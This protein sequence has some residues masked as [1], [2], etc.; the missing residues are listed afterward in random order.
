M[1]CYLYLIVDIGRRKIVVWEVH[2]RESADLAAVL[3][4]QA[5]LAEG[6]IARPL[7]L[8]ADN[9]SPPLVHARACTAGQWMKVMLEKPGIVASCSRPRVSN[10]SLFSE[11]LFRTCKY[12][13][14][15]PNMGFATKACAQTW[16]KSFANWYNGD[17]FDSAI[18]FVTPNIRHA[19]QDCDA[20]AN[21][22]S[23]YANARAQNPERWSGK[24]RNWHPAGPVWLNPGTRNQRP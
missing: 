11:A 7:V 19:G 24:T 5:V 17:H 8:Q 23:L 4:R 16:V 18:R 2:E 12:R 15:R 9:G 20:L 13:P 22:A 14:D 3:I 21:R 6:C 1:F 10:D